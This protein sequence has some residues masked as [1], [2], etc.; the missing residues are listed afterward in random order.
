MKR[1]LAYI[2]AALLMAFVCRPVVAQSLQQSA[3]RTVRL[4][5]MLPL[6]DLNGDGRRMVEYYRGVLMACFINA[7]RCS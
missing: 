3:G 4:G 1:T 7:W 2:F 5:V 6:H